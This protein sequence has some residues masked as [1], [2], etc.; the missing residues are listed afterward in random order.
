MAIKTVDIA[1]AGVVE[2]IRSNMAVVKNKANGLQN[3][4]YNTYSTYQGDSE[5]FHLIELKNKGTLDAIVGISK[6]HTNSFYYYLIHAALDTSG[7]MIFVV[8]K[9]LSYGSVLDG[10]ISFGYT[11]D[12]NGNADIYLHI[13]EQQYYMISVKTLSWLAN[14]TNGKD[15]GFPLS[16]LSGEPEAVTWVQV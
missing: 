6:N 10:K 5:Y 15:S 7:S 3:Y 1:D 16:G 11:S 13:T 4:I 9:L 14:S 8:R 12:G 2:S